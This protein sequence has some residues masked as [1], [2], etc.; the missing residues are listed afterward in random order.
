VRDAG[1]RRDIDEVLSFFAPDAVRDISPM[2]LG[3][4]EDR[5]AICRFLKI[6]CGRVGRRDR[7]EP[8]DLGSVGAFFLDLVRSSSL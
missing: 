3:I 8:L 4:F 6:A 2:D 1:S 7:G 5:D